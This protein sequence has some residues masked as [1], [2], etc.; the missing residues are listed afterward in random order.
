ME[1]YS[2][3]YGL[4]FVDGKW[5]Y[6]SGY[7]YCA[8]RDCLDITVSGGTGKPELCRAC[9]EAG[10]EAATDEQC[11]SSSECQREDAYSGQ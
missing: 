10:C 11:C 9:E 4:K 3:K 8:C 7:V 6:L 2:V 1:D 5:E